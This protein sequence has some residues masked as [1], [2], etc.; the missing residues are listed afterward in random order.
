MASAAANAFAEARQ[1]MVHEHLQ[2]RDIENAQVLRAMGVVPREE[3]VPSMLRPW[4]YMDRPLLIGYEQTISQPYIVA[5]MTQALGLEGDE[6]VLEVGTGSGYQTAVLAELCA[7]VYSI[8]RIA[9]L[10]HRAAATLHRLG[11]RNIHL[12]VGDGT[13]GWPEAAPFDA[14]LVTAGATKLPPAYRDQ[15]R[16][17]GRL[18]IPV[19]PQGEQTLHRYTRRGD[20]LA[21]EDLGR[22]AF[23]PLVGTKVS[24]EN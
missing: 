15:L 12:R 11:Y 5:L 14:M 13:R 19:G 20:E 23:V 18:L 10:S 22:V 3:F 24:K 21:D 8:E 9:R 2:P 4:A 16:E 17:G 6:R 7:E 1:R